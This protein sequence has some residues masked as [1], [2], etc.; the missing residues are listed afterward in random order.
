MSLGTTPPGNTSEPQRGY[1]MTSDRLG[2]GTWEKEDGKLATAIWGD[3]EVTRL[4]GGPFTTE[5][6]YERLVT[7]ISN[8]RSDGI[9][10]WPIFRLDTG[11]QLGCCGLRPRDVAAGVLELGFQLRRE[12]WGQG[13][14]SEAAKTVIAWAA[15]NGIAALIAG[16][17]PQNHAS[18]RALRRLG[19]TYTH[20]E[21]YSPTD[22]M[23]PC[24]R[25]QIAVH[26]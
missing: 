15:A 25:L 5:Q 14:A 1:H 21:H 10:Y 8:L 22:K 20:D 18:A 26:A 7:E 4:T 9:Q 24:Y 13:Y 16:H 2:F 19:F 12:A 6:V 11:E 23:E 3:P 17:H